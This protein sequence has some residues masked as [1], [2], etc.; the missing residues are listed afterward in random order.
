MRIKFGKDR[1]FWGNGSQSLLLNDHSADYLLLNI[2]TK[3]WK[4]VYTNHFTQMI[5]FIPNRNDTE[6]TLPRK[7]G[8]FHQLTY[9]P[10]SKLSFSIFESV[11]I[12]LY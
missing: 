8:V 3:I 12:A 7:Y 4:L 5:H 10:N 2:Q 9:H 1:A 11:F 6:G